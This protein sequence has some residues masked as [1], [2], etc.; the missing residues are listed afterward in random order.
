MSECFLS[1][2]ASACDIRIMENRYHSVRLLD[3]AIAWTFARPVAVSNASEWSRAQW[4]KACPE[5]DSG[6]ALFRL[7]GGQAGY[8]R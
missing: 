6:H 3:H 4:E 5:T 8:V 7:C 2:A 1:V